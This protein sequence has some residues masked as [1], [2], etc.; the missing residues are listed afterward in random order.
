M[1]SY[2]EVYASQIAATVA[3]PIT[4]QD[5]A[6]SNGN[7][8]SLPVA[9]NATAL[10]HLTASTPMGGG[11]TVNFEAS[12]NGSDWTAIL[13]SKVGT[14]DV[15]T[16]TTEPGDWQLNVSGYSEV[17]TRISAYSAGVITVVGYT[18][19]FTAGSG[20]SG[21]GGGDVNIDEVAGT[22]V[23]TDNGASGAGTLRITLAEN[24]TGQVKLATGTNN[25]G[26]ITDITGTVSLPTGA[27]TAA[28][29]PSLGTAGAASSDV[30]T[31][32]GI[33][34]MTPLLVNGSAVTQPISAAALPL[35]TGAATSA[36]QPA[37]GS[38]G[39]AA[40]DVLTVQGIASMTPLLVNGSGVTQPI[41]AA[42]LPLPSGAATAAKQPALGTAGSAATDVITVQGIAS[43]TPIKVDASGVSLTVAAPGLE[44]AQDSATSGQAGPLIQG[45]VSTSAP[46]YTNAKTN[47]LSLTTAGALR[48][49]ASGS[50][51]PISA[52][53]LPLPSG[54]A[55]SAKQPSLGTAGS[56]STDVISVQGV[57]SGTPLSVSFASS[58]DINIAKISGNTAASGSG[59]SSS[60][61]LRVVTSSDSTI[62]QTASI[63][64][65][66][67]TLQNAA[68]AN[69]NG[70][71]INTGGYGTCSLSITGSL[72]GGT[73]VN[74]ES[75]ADGG[76]TWSSILGTQV[77]TTTSA[78]S[79]TSTG[80][81]MF[82]CAALSQL[83]ARI[84]SYGSG[85]VTVKG[86]LSVI[87]NGGGGSGGGGGSVI[88]NL[89][90]V[91]SNAVATGN[92]TASSGT[93]RVAI[94]SDSVISAT[95]SPPTRSTY[96]ANTNGTFTPLTSATDMIIFT[97]SASTTVKILE[98]QLS[99]EVGSTAAANM[100]RF[101][102]VKR[103]SANSG[104]TTT[105]ETIVS[106]DSNNSAATAVMKSYR[107]GSN[108]TLGTTVG[109]LWSGV[110][111]AALMSGFAAT[112]NSAFVIFNAAEYGQPIV[113]RGTAESICLNN[114]GSTLAGATPKVG[115]IIYFTEE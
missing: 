53:V 23:D 88:S 71:S 67:T 5:N 74:F 99:Y 42:A 89:T 78:T 54:A 108:P 58:Q 43:M 57:A 97:G 16:S 24:S 51:V 102:L 75:S 40:S 8:T 25:I 63:V 28:K 11:T 30:I 82:S 33:T 35:P 10:L 100:N 101:F 15:A 48:V 96:S 114:A 86:F 26:S 115:L 14:S 95:V 50:T 84:S 107:S 13:G 60:G 31:V 61:T 49:D 68:T 38:A 2:G 20:G 98:I 81:W 106:M 70:T 76:T 45:A 80:D 29:Q 104:G 32:Q 27:A 22:A 110:V 72:G 21:G 36:K 69:G 37:L 111:S 109:T 46:S 12:A 19:V 113:L 105:T 39:S 64:P 52:S 112:L 87:S 55:T 79:T 47:P 18:S 77:G 34:S 9:G 56:P 91:N 7:G 92:G 83:R 3:S 90:Q 17:R 44:L 4:M 93:Q 94:A 85:T 62:A 41:S 103:S 65:A 73:T 66:F 6:S 1:S 59:A